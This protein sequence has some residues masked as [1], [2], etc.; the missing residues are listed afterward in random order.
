MADRGGDIGG[1]YD[2]RN[3]EEAL[4][5]G[6]NTEEAMTG[7]VVVMAWEVVTMGGDLG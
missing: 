2:G 6:Q 3:K 4:Y 7:M 5:D 1:L